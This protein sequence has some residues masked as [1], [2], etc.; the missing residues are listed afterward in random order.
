MRCWADEEPP[1]AF[2]RGVF[3]GGFAAGVG[4]A[5]LGFVLVLAAVG[6]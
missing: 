3:L 4:A 5:T 6:S 2:P 1:P